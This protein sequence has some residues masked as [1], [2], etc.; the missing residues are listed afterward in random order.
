[1]TNTAASNRDVSWWK[2]RGR[3]IGSVAAPR[4]SCIGAA[5]RPRCATSNRVVTRKPRRA[6]SQLVESFARR[7]ERPL[8]HRSDDRTGAADAI[9]VAGDDRRAVPDEEHAVVGADSR[10]PDDGQMDVAIFEDLEIAHF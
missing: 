6:G 3:R 9:D 10:R 4:S 8:V 5:S 7:G 1:M 2:P